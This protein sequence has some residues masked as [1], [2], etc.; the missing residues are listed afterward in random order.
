MGFPKY[1]G[2]KESNETAGDHF[3]SSPVSSTFRGRLIVESIKMAAHKMAD[4]LANGM[5][6]CIIMHMN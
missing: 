4:S 2:I 1:V 3:R 5:F 6:V